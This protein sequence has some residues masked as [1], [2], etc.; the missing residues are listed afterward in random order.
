M[1]QKDLINAMDR[2]AHLYKELRFNHPYAYLANE[3]EEWENNFI[4][5]ILNHWRTNSNILDAGC[6]YG[7][8]LQMLQRNGFKSLFGIDVSKNMIR[9]SLEACHMANLSVSNIAGHIPFRE[10]AFNAVICVGGTLGNIP[11]KPK[12]LKEFWRIL[13]PKG[14]VILGV[15]NA[16]F[17]EES[18]L[19][20]YYVGDLE[21]P[22]TFVGIDKNTRTVIMSGMISHWFT[23]SELADLLLSHGFDNLKLI[24]NFIYLYAVAEKDR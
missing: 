18:F 13:V 3:L 8:S 16:D 15:L 11:K 7:R 2:F 24:K 17:F 10:G 6:G 12:T 19:R 9:M 5:S 20:S 22:L 4:I 23:E 21:Y 1:S 14:T